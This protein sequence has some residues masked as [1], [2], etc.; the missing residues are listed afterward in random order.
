MSQRLAAE[1]ECRT[2][3]KFAVCL[4]LI[5]LRLQNR[6]VSGL[7][8]RGKPF[9]DGTLKIKSGKPDALDPCANRGSTDLRDFGLLLGVLFQIAVQAGSANT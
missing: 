5:Y 7:L 3:A 2:G 4:L 8:Q 9:P 6:E 1:Y